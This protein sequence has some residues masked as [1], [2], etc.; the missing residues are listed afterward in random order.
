MHSRVSY[1]YHSKYRFAHEGTANNL[2]NYKRST[3]RALIARVIA[4][5]I[6]IAEA[7]TE[8]YLCS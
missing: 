8:K 6:I 5:K 4:C 7:F 3:Q 1:I 2:A